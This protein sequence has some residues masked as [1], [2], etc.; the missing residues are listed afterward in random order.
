MNTMLTLQDIERA[1]ELYARGYWR[2][3]TLYTSF[4][5]IGRSAIP[6][7]LRCATQTLG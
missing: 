6:M 1:R 3:D 2:A 5:R 4:A 7:D